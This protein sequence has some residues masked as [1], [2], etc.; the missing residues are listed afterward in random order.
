MGVQVTTRPRLSRLHKEVNKY[1]VLWTPG[2]EEADWILLTDCDVACAG[3]LDG[4]EALLEGLDFA[5]VSDGVPAR[6]RRSP[7]PPVLR[8]DYFLRLFSG[9]SG[10]ELKQHA[11]PEFIHQPPFT[12]YPYFNGG[13]MMIRGARLA[14]FRETIVELSEQ[15]FRQACRRQLNP[16][17]WIQQAWNNAWF[18]SRHA[19]RLS[20]G[21][22]MRQRYADQAVI[23]PCLLKLGLRYT[24]LP[25]AYNWRYIEIGAKNPPPLLIHYFEPA[26]GIAPD[27]ILSRHWLD[28]FAHSNDEGRQ[29]LAGLVHDYLAAHPAEEDR[30]SFS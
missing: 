28:A 11:H 9:L 25:H 5:A 24:V 4:L 16:L 19:H 22:H 17:R 1:N 2:L 20:L 8:Y 3:P 18:R 23:L 27:R 10:R 6:S 13:V 26:L 14:S 30:R 29:A 12:R 21:W 7:R 15:V